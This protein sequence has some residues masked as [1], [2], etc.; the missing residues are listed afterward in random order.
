VIDVID[1]MPAWLRKRF[2]RRL[3]YIDVGRQRVGQRTYVHTFPFLYTS[4]SGKE[5]A[6][7]PHLR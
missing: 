4:A 6:A 2:E 5:T 3:V 7:L 1:R